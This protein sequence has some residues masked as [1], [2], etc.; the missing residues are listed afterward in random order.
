MEYETILASNAWV[1]SGGMI[2][3]TIGV[4]FLVTEFFLPS[5]GLFGFAGAASILIGIVQLHQTGY[6][7]EMPVSINT[8]IILSIIAL[9]LAMAG[10]LYTYALYQKKNTTGVEAMLGSEAT[11]VSWHGKEGTVQIFGENWQAYSDEKY[12]LKKGN[13]VLV[14]RVED[15]KI[16]ISYTASDE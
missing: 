7:D 6:I 15:L 13:K 11:I 8:L 9:L 14:S 4:A 2:L 16:K 12:S 5:F 3:L 1:N 10:A